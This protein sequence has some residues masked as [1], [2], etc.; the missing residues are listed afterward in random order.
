[1]FDL[2]NYEANTLMKYSLKEGKG[3]V[4]I[5]CSKEGVLTYSLVTQ[6]LTTQEE[7]IFSKVL[8]Q[9]EKDLKRKE[10]NIFQGVNP[11]HF[12]KVLRKQAKKIDEKS[13]QRLEQALMKV[14]NGYDFVDALFHDDYIEN[15]VINGP[16]RPVM[17][18][19]RKF[20][21]LITNIYPTEPEISRLQL[22][23]LNKVKNPELTRLS[24]VLNTILLDLTFVNMTLESDVSPDSTLYIKKFNQ[25]PLTIFDLLN[26]KMV[27][28]FI[29]ANI[30]FALENGYSI[31][32]YGPKGS[33]KS[34]F[35]NAVKELI[36]KR[37][38]GIC[39]ESMPFLQLENL[40]VK[41]LLTRKGQGKMDCL[42]I[43]EEE[44]TTFDLMRAAQQEHPD[45]LIID[46]LRGADTYTAFS[47]MTS[48]TQVLSTITAPSIQGLIRRLDSAPMNIPRALIADQDILLVEVGTLKNRGCWEENEYRVE[49]RVEGVV[50]TIGIDRMDNTLVTNL[51]S[52]RN[53]EIDD[54]HSIIPSY[55][56]DS[57]RGYYRYDVEKEL[58][59]R[60][61]YLCQFTAEG[62]KKFN[63]QINMDYK[64]HYRIIHVFKNIRRKLGSLE[65]VEK[66][67]SVDIIT[68][69]LTSRKKAEENRKRQ[70]SQMLKTMVLLQRIERISKTEFSNLL[71]I[72][73]INEFYEW[74]LSQEENI[75]IHLDGDFV[76]FTVTDE[77]PHFIDG[78]LNA[79]SLDRGKMYP[80]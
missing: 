76:V 33:G 32:V 39:I 2:S 49:F 40:N 65:E 13:G 51:I 46:E 6:R 21:N 69:Y 22:N 72:T 47:L 43:R 59:E 15:I 60:S 80:L 41:R 55:L 7:D 54:F 57:L 31:I 27:T 73:N 71:G 4:V 3:D 17:I 70:I 10:G 74:L 75:P 62:I 77:L 14:I 12:W 8:K 35:L 64:E 42:G 52:E 36:S 26:Q 48:K 67:V 9:L 79:F 61:R 28:G 37:K 29:L 24:P 56:V 44:V 78:L 63:Y 45:Y 30:W 5:Y 38:R 1:M 11:D 18:E 25:N 58:I 19:H 50:E 20:G 34:T 16:Q 68:G 53:K 23:F 66:A